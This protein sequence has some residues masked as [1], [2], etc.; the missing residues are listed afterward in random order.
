MNNNNINNYFNNI[1][2]FPQDTYINPNI[3]EQNSNDITNSNME[4][5]NT[6]NNHLFQ[7][8]SHDDLDIIPNYPKPLDTN[9]DQFNY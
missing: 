5:N 9:E 1:Y 6:E 3:T 4:I 8:Q 2:P 7:R